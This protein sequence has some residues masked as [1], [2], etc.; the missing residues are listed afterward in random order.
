L[1]INE[2]VSEIKSPYEIVE[3]I[4][5]PSKGDELIKRIQE[6][7]SAIDVCTNDYNSEMQLDDPENLRRD[8]INGV[9]VV[10]VKLTLKEPGIPIKGERKT[11]DKV[12]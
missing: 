3:E 12:N 10:D 7:I 1:G 2:P 4:R 9:E 11:W 6:S 5:K 8:Q